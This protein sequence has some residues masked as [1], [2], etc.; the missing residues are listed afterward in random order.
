MSHEELKKKLQTM[1]EKE[2]DHDKGQVFAYTY[3]V[4]NDHY[5][6]QKDIFDMFTGSYTRVSSVL[7]GAGA[8]AHPSTRTHA[9][10]HA[11]TTKTKQKTH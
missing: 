4:A 3:T 1:K 7:V 8:H 6:L 5:D 10:T 9:C 11:R 2:M